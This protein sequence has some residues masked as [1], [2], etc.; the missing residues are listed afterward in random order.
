MEE[1]TEPGLLSDDELFELRDALAEELHWLCLRRWVLFDHIDLLR[2]EKVRRLRESLAASGTVEAVVAEPDYRSLA[3]R[4][5][6]FSGSGN[7]D[8]LR[9]ESE[10]PLAP[11]PH[12]SSLEIDGIRTLLHS[13]KRV[14]DDVSLR[15]QIVWVR[16]QALRTEVSRRF[17]EVDPDR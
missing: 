11:L 15:R 17:D 10:P 9:W 8:T 5:G 7:I 2:S 13:T 1:F 3:R 6:D 4:S 14:E 12:V 16:L